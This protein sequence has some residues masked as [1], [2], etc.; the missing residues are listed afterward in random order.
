MTDE[1]SIPSSSTTSGPNSSEFGPFARD[2]RRMAELVE[3]RDGDGA[4]LGTALVDPDITPL[5]RAEITGGEGVDAGELADVVVR[6]FPNHRLVAHDQALTEALLARG[7]ELVRASW[8]MTLALPVDL[9]SVE[10]VDVRPMG[11]DASEYARL[12]VKAY[13]PGHPDH[14]HTVGSH[15]AARDTMEQFFAGAIVGPFIPDASVEARDADGAL[16]GYCVISEMPA[17]WRY[18][19]GPWVTDVSVH[20]DA[21]GRG[22]GRAMVAEA[23]RRLSAAGFRSLGLAVTQ[24]NSV[25]KRLYDDL[26]FV[27]HFPAWTM[28]L[29]ADRG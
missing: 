15:S 11:R 22:V 12:T 27:E 4:V 8:M 19:G 21:Q 2:D 14:D 5:P 6:E 23:I 1:G 18:E 28:N 13:G 20:P 24:S 10:G 25:A 29:T 16:L 7:A 26:G 9:P 17:E 3:L